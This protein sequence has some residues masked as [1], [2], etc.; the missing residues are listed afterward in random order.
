MRPNSLSVDCRGILPGPFVTSVMWTGSDFVCELCLI[1][2]PAVSKQH[3]QDRLL[4]SPRQA[5]A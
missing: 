2:D 3:P 5:G 1:G 4:S